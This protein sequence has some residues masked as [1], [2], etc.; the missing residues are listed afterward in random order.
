[1]PT[2]L[3]T[4][5]KGTAYLESHGVEEARL[6]MQHL[7][8]QTLECE[9]MQLYIDFDLP[10]EETQLETLR[11]LMKRRAEG[12]PL[13]HLLGT[14]E[15]CD[16]EFKSD[17]RALI[18]RP[19][20]EELVAKLLAVKTWPNPAKI[21]DVGCGSGVIGLSLA[22]GI[23]GAEV[24][25]TD[26]SLDALELAK[27]NATALDIKAT[28]VES[29]LFSNVPNH[30][31]DLI[32]A[33]LPYIPNAEV[34]QLSREVQHDPVLALAGGEIGTELMFQLISESFDLLNANGRLVLE[35]GIGQAA[36][37]KNAA[38]SAGFETVKVGRDFAGIERFLFAVKTADPA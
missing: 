12:E 9:R 36:A 14:V 3:D 37:L 6:N 13:Q 7:I 18:P 32:V 28:F 33:N 1:M 26:I 4:L 16:R 2:L 5:Q 21:L 29:N 17:S 19:E 22:A 11:D 25:L 30:P 35:Y 38:E 34:P 15:F 24:V 31:F 20:T 10:M 23:E 27:K 8:A